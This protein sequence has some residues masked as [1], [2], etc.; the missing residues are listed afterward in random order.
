MSVSP[1]NHDGHDNHESVDQGGSLV[2]DD[3][4]REL[5]S[6]QK[7][8][9]AALVAA[10]MLGFIWLR[11]ADRPKKIA[12]PTL[13]TATVSRGHQFRSAPLIPPPPP[14]VPMPVQVQPTLPT[15]RLTRHEMTPA[16][17]P[18]FAAGNGG[19]DGGGS[20]PVSPSGAGSAQP[21]PAAGVQS[22][23]AAQENRDSPL[24]ARLKP[25]V[26]KAAEAHMLPHP[27]FLITKGTIIP[28]ILQTRLNTQLA[29]YTKCIIPMDIRSTTGNVVLLDKGTIIIG[30]M[31]HGLMRGQD[32]VFVVWDRAE[33]PEHSVI[34]LASPSTDELG[35][36]GIGVT[37]NNHWW[38]RF[39]SAILLSVIQGALDVGVEAASR[40]GASGSSSGSYFNSFQSNG[41]TVANSALQ[42]NINMEPT[43]EKSQGSTIAI[44]V[45]RDLDFSGIYD[46]RPM[47]GAYG[48]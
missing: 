19:A 10:V 6:W 45:A 24:A 26:L 13:Q 46:L 44:F 34:E 28:C 48:Q 41:Q 17:S 4:R 11:A 12:Q 27:D 18:I 37:V 40:I 22:K 21:V 31:Q 14:P 23:K 2:S 8:G 15:P 38:E 5:T 25:T 16:E 42:A 29:G 1:E 20:A 9:I 7:I 32:R 43:G 33:T 35:Q 3:K 36:S 39:G 30:E 47:V